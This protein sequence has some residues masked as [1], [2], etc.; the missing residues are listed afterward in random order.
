MYN[1]T[2]LHHEMGEILISTH[3]GS[4][5]PRATFLFT[6]KFFFQKIGGIPY[7]LKYL[8]RMFISVAK[9]FHF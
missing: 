5:E 2:L 4:H 7:L 1:F 9:L 6:K 8:K 3:M